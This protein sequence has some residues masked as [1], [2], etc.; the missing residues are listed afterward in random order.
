[1][2]F[3]KLSLLLVILFTASRLI[4]AE[5]EIQMEIN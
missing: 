4:A 2:F 3:K 5:E 1:M